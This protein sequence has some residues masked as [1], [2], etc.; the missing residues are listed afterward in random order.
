MVSRRKVLQGMAAATV[1]GL[2]RPLWATK[3]AG[4]FLKP[5]Q[6]LKPGEY[7]WEPELSP[8]GPVAIIVSLPEQMAHVYRN[9]V[10][11]GVTTVST[12]RKGHRTPTGVFVIL[13]KDR[14][15]HSSIYH[16]ASMPNTERL[17]WDGICLHAGGLPGYPSSH[18]CVHLP[19]DF[20]AKLFGITHLGT[21]VI[22]A[23]DHSAPAD[24]VHPGIV[25][26]GDADQIIAQ[27][28]ARE[29]RRKHKAVP[30]A[31]G[32]H[33]NRVPVAAVLVSGT[34]RKSY[35]LK[36]GE[37]AIE[38]TVSIANA[39]QPLGTHVLV[40]KS[41]EGKHPVWSSASIRHADSTTDMRNT[42][43]TTLDRITFDPVFVEQALGAMHPGMSLMITDLAAGAE[44][45][46]ERDFVIVTSEYVQS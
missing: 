43:G 18:G 14:H 16:N 24:V 1:L 46:S 41:F 44:T 9:G 15:H 26:S 36:D 19:L 23:D 31:A 38:K 37:I 21:P 27:E 45:R 3:K 42:D 13:Q 34:D 25:L 17:T 22:I 28:R 10:K 35:L 29:L 39:D 6:K 32:D 30:P 7:V 20:S 5:G 33:P 40:L 8:E 4:H 12:G 2:C 11:I